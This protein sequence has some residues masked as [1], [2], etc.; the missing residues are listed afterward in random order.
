MEANSSSSSSI[1]HG[2]CCLID[3]S[4]SKG[5]SN[6]NMLL[7]HERPNLHRQHQLSKRVRRCHLQ[8]SPLALMGWTY[9]ILCDL[10]PT[11]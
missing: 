8:T 10:L 2:E 1:A 5:L 6:D 7:Y 11:E 9:G 3:P 4:K